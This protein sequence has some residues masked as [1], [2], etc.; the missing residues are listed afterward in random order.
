MVCL[1]VGA[2]KANLSH[3]QQVHNCKRQQLLRGGCFLFSYTWNCA[4]GAKTF[5]EHKSSV[6]LCSASFV[7][8]IRIP[9][10]TQRLMLN[11]RT[12]VQAGLSY[13]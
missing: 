11:V 12:E 1:S 3:F 2:I 6:L 10:N 7:R 4:I 5:S 9:K 13:S 8:N